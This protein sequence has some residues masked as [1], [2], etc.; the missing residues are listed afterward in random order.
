MVN[1]P[2]VFCIDLIEGMVLQMRVPLLPFSSAEVTLWLRGLR[3]LKELSTQLDVLII[4]IL[5]EKMWLYWW[6]NF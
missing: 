6:Q 5:V 1:Q 3:S 4:G 2:K